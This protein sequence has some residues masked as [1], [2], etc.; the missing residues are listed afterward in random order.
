MIQTKLQSL[1][2]PS[3]IQTERGGGFRKKPTPPYSGGSLQIITFSLLKEA[4]LH[5]KPN[6]SPQRSDKKAEVDAYTEYN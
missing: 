2:N 5:L 6:V 3:S 1:L 4:V